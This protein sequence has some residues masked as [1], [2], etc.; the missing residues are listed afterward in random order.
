[1]HTG[2]GAL[3]E[4]LGDVLACAQLSK[5]LMFRRVDSIRGT[6]CRGLRSPTSARME[7]ASLA[8]RWASPVACASFSLSSRT[9]CSSSALRLC[10]LIGGRTA[11]GGRGGG[12]GGGGGSAIGSTFF[13][14][15]AGG[16]GASTTST[17]SGSTAGFGAFAMASRASLSSFV[18]RSSSV[19]LSSSSPSISP[20]CRA[21]WAI[22]VS[23]RDVLSSVTIFGASPSAH[24][25]DRRSSSSASRAASSTTSCLHSAGVRAEAR[26]TCSAE[27]ERERERERE[28][29][30]GSSLW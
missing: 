16:G 21:I 17:T 22:C 1:M 10:A 13:F 6:A 4:Y 5:D 11:G 3:G 30:L 24:C 8:A 14:S 19:S 12:G 7:S 25:C 20:S 23:T 26:S 2:H 15:T 27:R 29:A 18:T 28:H 9:R